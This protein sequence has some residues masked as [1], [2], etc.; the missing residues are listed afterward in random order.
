MLSMDSAL[1]RRKAELL[2]LVCHFSQCQILSLVLQVTS[3]KQW[4]T[5]DSMAVTA[6]TRL[7]GTLETQD[8]TFV[9]YA[10]NRGQ[11]Q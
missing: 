10:N 11:Q 5:Q 6:D 1:R 2:S 4:G 7:A 8:R 9:N 3:P